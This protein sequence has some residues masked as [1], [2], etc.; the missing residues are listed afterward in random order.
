MMKALRRLFQ[1]WLAEWR[2]SV[3]RELQFRGNF[4]LWILVEVCWFIL[5]LAF[6]QVLYLNVSS[7]AGWTKW[8]MIL[9]VGL[10]Q[11]IQQLFQTFFLV[12]FINF[13]ELI[14][15]GKLDFYLLQPAP[16]LLLVST[17]QWDIGSVFNSL[18]AAGVVGYAAAQLH[19]AVTGSMALTALALVVAGVGVHYAF[20]LLIITPAF[21]MTRAQGFI[22]AYYQAFQLARQP[23]EAYRGALRFIL[24]W[25]I[26]LL[27]VANLPARALLSGLHPAQVAWLFA[28]TGV[29][30]WAGIRFFHF[31]LK[32]YT[33]AS[34]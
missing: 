33:S 20:L 17:R 22:M 30:L 28:I 10:S 18:F 6:V 11:F 21:W 26:P 16:I 1:V 19:L 32:R 24:S 5:Q 13:P 25:I 4:I 15:T 12:N 8:E 14:R 27:L 3:S 9:L 34:S 2:Y 23:R 7:I 29:L 31:G